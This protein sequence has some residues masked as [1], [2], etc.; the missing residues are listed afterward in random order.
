MRTKRTNGNAT[1]TYTY[2]GSRL[3]QMTYSYQ[4]SFTMHFYYDASGNPMS[5][6]YSGATYYYVLN[7]LGDV[8]AILNSSGEQVVGY[9]YDAWGKLLTT[10]GS[11]ASTLGL[12]NP[13]RYRGYVYDRETSLYYLQSRYYNPTWGRFINADAYASTGQG[14]LGYNMFAYCQNNPVIFSDPTGEFILTALIVGV[15]AGAAIGGAIGGTV[16]YN[17]AKSS[18]LGGTDL[19]CATASGVGKGALMGG[20]AAGLVGATGG[21]VAAYGAASVAG[22]AMITATA[23]ITAKAAEVV[24]LQAT[25]SVND[26]DNGWQI[27]NDCISSIF[28]NGGKIISPALTKAGTT[29]ATY[30]ATDLTKHKVVS[31]GFNTFLHSTGGKVFPYAFAAYAWGNTAYSIVCADPIARANQRGYSLI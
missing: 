2:N 31:H 21:F 19:L 12:Y 17:S 11:M 3:S 14:I 25:K 5:F 16:A 1:Y 18:G 28:S 24:A 7:L 9:T 23:T 30:V 29:S 13:L 6:T 20:V 8:V 4:G 15:I 10:T 27:A 22:T 26:G